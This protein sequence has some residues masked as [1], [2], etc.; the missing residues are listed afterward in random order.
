MNYT[1]G[2]RINDTERTKIE[3]HVT[4]L[5]I[6]RLINIKQKHVV[7]EQNQLVIGDMNNVLD[8]IWNH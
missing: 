2:S 8:E 3:I 4:I 1:K 6:K 7:V 5:K